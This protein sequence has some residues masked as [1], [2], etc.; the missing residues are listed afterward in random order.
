[1][2]S[3]NKAERKFAS[4]KFASVTKVSAVAF[5]LTSTL[6]SANKLIDCVDKT[7]AQLNIVTAIFFN[8]FMSSSLLLFIYVT[9]MLFFCINITQQIYSVNKFA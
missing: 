1:M 6:S 8:A 4:G 9:V 3:F 5:C 7:S 2:F